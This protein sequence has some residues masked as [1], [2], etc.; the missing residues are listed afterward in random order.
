ME[1]EHKRG[2]AR[3]PIQ[4]RQYAVK[5][6][7]YKSL[8]HSRKKKCSP[9][10]RNREL[11]LGYA[12]VRND[13]CHWMAVMVGG[14]NKRLLYIMRWFSCNIVSQFLI[15]CVYLQWSNDNNNNGQT[16]ECQW[17]TLMDKT[18][19]LN[20]YWK[21]IWYKQELDLY[22]VTRVRFIILSL[23]NKVCKSSIC[24]IYTLFYTQNWSLGEIFEILKEM[25]MEKM[26]K[27]NSLFFSIFFYSRQ[28][29]DWFRTFDIYCQ[30]AKLSFSYKNKFVF[31]IR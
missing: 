3:N 9:F 15:K 24:K 21:R 7:I 11:F 28:C 12:I 20:R 18:P 4:Y 22:E 6:K 16:L 17:K 19:L 1:E 13:C 31:L 2:R 5:W 26:N 23:R 29:K 10:R 8:P 30:C 27:H 14:L 25:L